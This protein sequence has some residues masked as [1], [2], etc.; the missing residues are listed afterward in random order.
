MKFHIPCQLEHILEFLHLYQCKFVIDC[1]AGEGGHSI[2]IAKLVGESGKVI[3]IEID[4]SY[5]QKLVKNTAAF[6]NI[7]CVN[8][9]YL[10]IKNVLASVGISRIDA[11]LFDFG[12]SS[13]HLESSGRGFSFRKDEILD[14]RF[15]PSEG[16]PLYVKLQKLTDHDLELILKKF[17]EVKFAKKLAKNLFANKSKVKYTSHLVEIAGKSIPHQF[18]NSELPKIFQAFRIFT[19]NEYKNM[20]EGLKEAIQVLPRGGILI[21]LSYHSIEDR[22]CKSIKNIKGMKVVTKKP[23]TPDE[24]ET[25]ENSRCRSSKLRVFEKEE[26]DEESLV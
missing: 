10:E 12:L 3:A 1:T 13:Y 21:T 22:L 4:P 24:K 5:F 16:E 8:A 17:G 23:I 2:A 9:S 11:I 19:N 6:S 15:N 18:L 20:V 14:M 7:T 26:V 25:S